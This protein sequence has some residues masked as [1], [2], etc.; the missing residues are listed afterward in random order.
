MFKTKLTIGLVLSATICLSL[1]NMVIILL[2]THHRSNTVKGLRVG[3]NG[4]VELDLAGIL[5][6]GDA[7]TNAFLKDPIINKHD[8]KYIHNPSGLCQ[9][10][11][12]NLL[13]GVVS[14][15]KNFWQ[16]K[17][18][19]R[20]GNADDGIIVVFV[21]GM[22]DS[23]GL[24]R[25]VNQEFKHHNDVLQ[26]AIVETPRNLSLKTVALLKWA[27]THCSGAKFVLKK[28]DDVELEP[29]S[30]LNALRRKYEQFQNFIMGN[31][32]YL[33]EGPIRQ[34]VSKYYTSY[35]E[36]GEPFFPMFVH[37]PAYGFPM[38]TV[39]ILYQVSLRTKLFWLE[40]V[41]VTGICAKR[42]NIPVFFDIRFIYEHVGIDM[43]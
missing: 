2:S 14:T 15:P 26:S 27:S 42:A 21:L 29:Y 37:G 20:F 19:R 41:Y 39:E 7:P 16:R 17:R 33:V 13:V 9:N 18:G 28:D 3:D 6:P 11:T 8:Y 23:N 35:A 32:K 34:E 1:F 22:A 36:Y 43:I 10:R 38:K 25:R 12:I 24:Q 40:D 5:M 4:Q 30:I 31:S